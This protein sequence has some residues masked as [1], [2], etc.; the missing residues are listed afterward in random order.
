[1]RAAQLREAIRAVVAE[2]L[3][4]RLPGLVERVLSE[5]Y[6]DRIVAERLARRRPS[7]AES[8]EDEDEREDADRVPRPLENSDRGIY[9]DNGLVKT[10]SVLRR[11]DNPL[12]SLY[13][14]VRPAPRG[15]ATEVAS[16]T[17]VRL[18]VLERAGADFEKMR[19]LAGA[20]G[21][22]A[23]AGKPDPAVKMREL[24]ERRRA[25]DVP[26]SQWRG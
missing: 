19:V 14:G 2:E 26:V 16:A 17:N 7:L 3:R 5:R 13:E 9:Q 21:G 12:A 24:E 1:M 4:A 8:L 22:P 18:D 11:S 23:A 25:L 15:P 6:L 20:G 10:E